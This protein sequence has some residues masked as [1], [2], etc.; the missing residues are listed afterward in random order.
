MSEWI[1]VEER[2]PKKQSWVLVYCDGAVRCWGFDP[3]YGWCDGDHRD[4]PPINRITHWM[5]IPPDPE[6]QKGG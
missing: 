4:P 6:E 1:S 2:L 5:E 3:K